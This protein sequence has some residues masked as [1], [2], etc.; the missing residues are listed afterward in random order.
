MGTVWE[1]KDSDC[2]LAWGM[3]LERMVAM[4]K[5][6]A[7][8]TAGAKSPQDDPP[9][10]AR[11]IKAFLNFATSDCRSAGEGMGGLGNNGC[12]GLIPALFRKIWL[13]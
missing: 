3:M 9:T 13:Y 4:E 12:F 1:L 11:H 2:A 5:K 6:P 8:A 7:E 10:K